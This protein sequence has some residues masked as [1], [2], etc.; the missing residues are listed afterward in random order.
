MKPGEG[1][2]EEIKVPLEH[3]EAGAAALGSMKER[4]VDVKMK[5]T[6][7]KGKKGPAGAGQEAASINMQK[8]SSRVAG[9]G[10]GG[11]IRVGPKKEPYKPKA[12]PHAH[13]T[14]ETLGTIDE[15]TEP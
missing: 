13:E 11:A 12:Q 3:R 14:A 7:V 6:T 5:K 8:M 1:A 2:G 9:G 15:D 4:A 10:G